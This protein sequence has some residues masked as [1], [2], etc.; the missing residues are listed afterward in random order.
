MSVAGSI[1]G[2]GGL[3]IYSSERLLLLLSGDKLLS[4]LRIRD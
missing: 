4:F 2:S 3:E 1:Q